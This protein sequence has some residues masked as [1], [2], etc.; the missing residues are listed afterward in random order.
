MKKSKTKST[1]TTFDLALFTCGFSHIA[2]GQGTPTPADLKKVEQKKP[3][4]SPYPDQRFPTRVFWG[5]THHHTRLSFDDGL[6][7]TKL[8]PEDAYR[9]ARGEEVI[10]STG[11]LAKLSRPLDFLVVSDHA[12]YMGLADLLNNADPDLLA[13]ESERTGM[14]G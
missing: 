7:G 1:I 5:D 4:Y 3:D 8:G 9:F 12:E 6:T 13:T 2:L 11:Q 14:T 10:S